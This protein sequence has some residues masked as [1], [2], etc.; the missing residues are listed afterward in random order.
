MILSTAWN[1]IPRRS[2]SSVMVLTFGS[3]ER[4]LSTGRI[5]GGECVGWE[6]E[7]A[8]SVSGGTISGMC[9]GVT[10]EGEV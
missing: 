8:I 10:E 3:L 7:V 9:V 1:P 5:E 4:G 2:S 6:M